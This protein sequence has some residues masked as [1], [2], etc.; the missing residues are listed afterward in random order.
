MWFRHAKPVADKVTREENEG[1]G[2]SNKIGRQIRPRTTFTGQKGASGLAS[3]T[4]LRSSRNGI[5]ANCKCKATA[6]C[7]PL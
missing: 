6:A 7:L 4:D 1:F 3:W 5:N 2:V